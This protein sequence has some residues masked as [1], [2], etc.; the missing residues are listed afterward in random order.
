MKTVL[1]IDDNVHEN[2]LGAPVFEI[3]KKILKLAGFNVHSVGFGVSAGNMDRHDYAIGESNYRPINRARKFLG[4]K[5]LTNAVGDIIESVKP[6]MIHNHLISKY[7]GSVFEAIPDDIF[8]VQTLHGP[9]FFCPTSL[10]NIVGTSEKCELGVS[11]KCVDKGCTS[12]PLYLAYKRLHAMTDLSKVDIF[13]CPSK[14]IERVANKLG[15]ENTRHVPLGIREVFRVSESRIEKKITNTLLFVGSLHPV[16]GLD[17]LFAAIVVVKQQIPDVLVKVAGRGPF[18]EHYQDLSV[19][20]GIERNVE[21]FGYVSSGE[22]EQL[23][24]SADITVVPSVWEEQ[25]GMIGP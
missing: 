1:L 8:L 18:L 25:F 16:K 21:F 20:L 19:S 24:K 4:S 3:E 5:G 17:Y 9:N 15:F 23:Y 11:R 22:I 7:P 14:Y 6:D 10:G 12:I 13:H 2:G